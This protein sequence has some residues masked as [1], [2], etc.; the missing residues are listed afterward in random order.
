MSSLSLSRPSPSPSS[1]PAPAVKLDPFA[2]TSAAVKQAA[3][4]LNIP[5]SAQ[6]QQVVMTQARAQAAAIPVLVL[7]I[8]TR[9]HSQVGAIGPERDYPS[10]EGI[11]VFAIQEAR[12]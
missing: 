4:A 12:L 9:D 2:L 10:D 5:R 7:P 11:V 6:L 3:A 1:L 8:N